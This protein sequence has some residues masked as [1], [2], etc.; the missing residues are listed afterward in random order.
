MYIWS[1]LLAVAFNNVLI[2]GR[3]EMASA[4]SSYHI[5]VDGC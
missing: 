2:H 1:G 5:T 3:C 4:V